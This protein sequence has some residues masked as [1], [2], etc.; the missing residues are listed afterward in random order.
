M[1]VVWDDGEVALFNDGE[2]DREALTADAIDELADHFADSSTLEIVLLEL[3]AHV[4]ELVVA[5]HSQAA[6]NAS[7]VIAALASRTSR[8]VH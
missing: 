1:R 6:A 8:T 3:A 5:G 4:E 2:D 7:A